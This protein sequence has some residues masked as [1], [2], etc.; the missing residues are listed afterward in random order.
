MMSGSNGESIDFENRIDVITQSLDDS[1]ILSK[2][3]SW[4]WNV[5]TNQ[6]SWS[7][8]M[9]RILG[10]EP[11]SLEPSY[12]L[13]LN[14]VHDS[15]KELYENALTKAIQN[16]TEYY[17]E[18]R[19]IRKDNC[20]I[21]VISRGR[22]FFDKNNNF[23]RMIG[24]VQDVSIQKK[25]E[26]ANLDKSRAEENES[27]FRG[28][29][30]QSHVGTAIVGLN[31]CIV[32]CN[33]AFC[34]FLGYS[35][36]EI[37]G[38]T[39]AYFTH[40]EDL[41]I[42]M[43]EMKRIVEGEID[44][45]KVQK[46][47]LRKD[48][49]I[50]WGELTISIV[51]S[52]DNT[53]L[54]FLSIIQDVSE[55]HNSIKALEESEARFKRMFENHDAIMLLIEPETGLIINANNAASKFYGYSKSMICSLKI[56]DINGMSAEQLINVR[57]NILDGNRN[58]FDF[59][60]KLENGEM[61]NVEVLSTPIEYNQQS[62][63]FSIIHD[64][65]DRKYAEEQLKE[66]E[67]K[68]KELVET[69][70]I[71][72]LIDD[73]NGFFKYFNNKF[74]EIF[75]FTRKEIDQLPIRKLVHPDDV[76]IVMNHHDSRVRGE[77]TITKYEFRGVRKNGQT[78]HLMVS[79]VPVKANGE[80]IGSQSYIWD[81]TE[82]KLMEA[83]LL[84]N[85]Q[86]NEKAQALGH[87]GNWEYNIESKC[88]WVSDESKRIYG[89]DLDSNN[90]SVEKTESC[91]PERERVHQALIDLIDYDKKYDLEYEVIPADKSPRRIIHSIAELERDASNNPFRV[92]GVILDITERKHATQI[93]EENEIRLKEIN[94]AKDKLFSIIAH[95][96]RSPFNGILG[97]S[98]LLIEN[99]KDIELSESEKYLDIIKSSAENTL[100]LLDNLLNWTRLQTGKITF[101]PK[102]ISLSSIIG[103]TIKLSQ[104]AAIGKGILINQNELDDI[105]V[106]ADK[107]MLKTVLRNLISN[108][109]KFT[110]SGGNV[111][112]LANKKQNQVEIAVSDDGV[113]M[114]EKTINKLFKLG[115][116]DT[117][118][119]TGDEK[120]SGLGL[121][122]C[123]DLV[124]K[125]GGKI[126]VESKL[127]KG[128]VFKIILPLNKS[129][130]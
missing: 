101:N 25:L 59:Q 4:D 17:F 16:K 48:G 32:K 23:V 114:N 105:E 50:V 10:I 61:R 31:K 97:F 44:F 126:W 63:L 79:V 39:V 98:E 95:D 78:I 68:Y 46:R 41:G 9:F 54:Y 122:L 3:G 33:E 20:V 120:G 24:T 102:K 13:A 121:I 70:D 127:G 73:E 36:K 7:K 94:A 21:P 91:I 82:R 109:I 93:I 19:I 51:R 60:H 99:I 129:Y 128:S 45:A 92:R 106:Y 11:N 30:T 67:I 80:I 22:C 89:F 124:E 117:T 58:Y 100:I 12:E 84:E 96:L 14:S 49:V 47:Y 83:L 2:I 75:G 69:A 64:V 26:K 123:K 52:S 8:N 27:Q 88:F 18:N 116:S 62:I 107:D 87:V 28:L 42:G 103:E 66:S 57:N 130:E 119:G 118:T 104:T 53:P 38:R 81:I 113:G 85:K 110:K 72:M 111:S 34:Y 35:E 77:K 6:V 43:H 1:Q 15:D 55:R 71:A 90:F 115:T 125:Q 29:F 86:R 5:V 56:T 108:A 112:V 40:P 65:T 74:C 76:E 37:L